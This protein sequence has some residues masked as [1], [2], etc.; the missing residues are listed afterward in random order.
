[1]S[2]VFFEHNDIQADLPKHK[3]ESPKVVKAVKTVKIVKTVKTP[4]SSQSDETIDTRNEARVAEHSYDSTDIDYDM[5]DMSED[6]DL[7]CDITDDIDVKHQIDAVI[8]VSQK[9]TG[10]GQ[11]GVQD[12]AQDD[13]QDN[14][15]NDPLSA[16]QTFIDSIDIGNEK[17]EV[18]KGKTIRFVPITNKKG[19][20]A[21]ILL[22]DMRN[23]IYL[24]HRDIEYRSG[25]SF[26]KYYAV[27]KYDPKK[28]IDEKYAK[29]TDEETELKK[30]YCV[31]LFNAIR[32]LLVKQIQ[33]YIRV[34]EISDVQGFTL[35]V[36]HARDRFYSALGYD[37]QVFGL[38]RLDYTDILR[39]CKQTYVIHIEG[40]RMIEE[41]ATLVMRLCRTIVDGD[42]IDQLKKHE[43][44]ISVSKTINYRKTKNVNSLRYGDTVR[45]KKNY[46][47]KSQVSQDMETYVRTVRNLRS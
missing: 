24:R 45:I 3:A 28:K 25:K 35:E 6:E 29:Y 40:L 30:K 33:G 41:R 13:V 9:S 7:S 17:V 10:D 32:T 15:Q 31:D 20:S 22:S 5:S 19:S 27:V 2:L 1:M 36:R 14:A 26:R 47:K 42:I 43:T 46:V 23:Q 4:K 16:A 11:G 34:P 18:T 39:D 37:N 8:D 12:N 38:K 44:K 21:F